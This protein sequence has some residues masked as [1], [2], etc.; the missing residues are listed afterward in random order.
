MRSLEKTLNSFPDQSQAKK[1][2]LSHCFS[3]WFLL[4]CFSSPVPLVCPCCSLV[5]SSSLVF[6]WVPK[7]LWSYNP[8]PK[9]SSRV[10]LRSDISDSLSH[11]LSCHFTILRCTK[12][13]RSPLWLQQWLMLA[14]SKSQSARNDK[15][16]ASCHHLTL[17]Q[18]VWFGCYPSNPSSSNLPFAW[19]KV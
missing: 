9:K 3:C 12:C 5:F 15:I 10:L 14:R 16:H 6:L 13:E 4:R 18:F 11:I 19:G 2:N 8:F 1:V 7:S 17:L